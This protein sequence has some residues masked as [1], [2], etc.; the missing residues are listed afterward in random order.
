MPPFL[1]TG[2]FVYIP[3][4]LFVSYFGSKG[5][6]VKWI[7]V[8]T[9]ITAIS[10]LLIFSS[11]FLFP[12]ERQILNYTAL[13][14]CVLT[15]FQFYVHSSS[16]L[17]LNKYIKGTSCNHKRLLPPDELFTPKAK[18][19]Q[20]FDYE[21]IKDRIDE[22]VKDDFLKKIMLMNN[23]SL[24]DVMSSWNSGYSGRSKEVAVV[25]DNYTLDE[26]LLSKIIQKM[27]KVI[28]GNTGSSDIREVKS[29]L[30]EYV[31][32]RINE[33]S[34][35]LDKVR[36]SARAP[37]AYCSKL[38]NEMRQIIKT[39]KC[40]KKSLHV[41]PIIVLFVGLILF[42][43]G[44]C[45][46]WSLGVPL[47]D[48]TFSKKNLPI[49]VAGMNFIRILG[50]VCGFLIG[51]LCSSFYYTL[52]PPPSLTAK[53]PTWIG[54]WWMGFLFIG[55]LL[56][57]PSIALYFFPL[58]QKSAIVP[59]SG[60]VNSDNDAEQ[61]EMPMFDKYRHNDSVESVSIY[62]KFRALYKAYVELLHSKIFV[63][64][65]IA[66]TFDLLAV[67][68]YMVFLP[69]Y[70]EIQFGIPQY[71]VHILMASFG[72]FG[73]AAGA[74]SGGIIVR[75][76]K[77]SGRGTAIFLV[78]FSVVNIALFFSKGLFGCYSTTSQV[79]V[80]G[81][82]TNYNYTQLCNAN[83]GC[84]SAPLYPICDKSG[85]AFFSPCHAGCRNVRI[86]DVKTH[87]LEFSSCQ[88]KPEEVLSRKNCQ[89][90]CNLKAMFFFILMIIGSF[91]GG[92][93]IVPGILLI[94]RSVPSIHRSI[95]LGFQGFMISLFASLP[96]PFIW[97]TI[98]DTTCLVWNYT[99]P[100]NKGACV[101]YDPILLRQR[102]H[103]TY[104]G[105]RLISAIADL[106]V[107]KHADSINIMDE[108]NDNQK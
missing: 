49:S 67:R 39:G 40:G 89:D 72:I 104:V 1:V 78:I 66:R 52:K 20:F 95:A 108:P 106:Y 84:Q 32:E 76:Q 36:N 83:C 5:N 100:E 21:P 96:S 27:H 38:I 87:E 64:L 101:I 16:I 41:R 44:R 61:K 77:F 65:L 30:Q 99:C 46:P 74:I 2:D 69:K 12:V 22:S 11:N 31:A 54:A 25:N 48:D 43:I 19:E 85:Y 62:I 24:H 56:I 70:L 8:G 35:D 98:V 97:G 58:R 15:Q 45:M 14:A 7:G 17:R 91:A 80:N 73:L 6:R 53:D 47:I 103:F 3:A 13:Q 50:P 102:L 79:G 81:R 23:Y 75:R 42:G 60:T 68:G 28:D 10:H 9:S 86:T 55:L 34:G 4:V 71:N 93:C 90:D 107:I 26:A 94:L 59:Q 92:N 33:T 82:S 18:F 37:F 29:L 57:G 63:A 88:C 105:I 51:S